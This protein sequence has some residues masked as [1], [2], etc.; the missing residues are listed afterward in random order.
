[1]SRILRFYFFIAV[2]LSPTICLSWGES[3]H[4]ITEL[5]IKKVYLDK[6]YVFC[7]SDAHWG[8]N[9]FGVFVFDRRTET[10][11]NYPSF[12]S[13]V[14]IRVRRVKRIEYEGDFVR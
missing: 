10:W 3:K 9:V 6:N 4:S 2:V 11:T 14:D 5:L 1:M 13:H 12:I 7:G 8:T